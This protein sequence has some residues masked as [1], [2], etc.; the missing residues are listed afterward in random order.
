MFEGGS[1]HH[2]E[3]VGRILLQV[4]DNIKSL[5]ASLGRSNTVANLD[6]VLARAEK[7]LRVK[8]EV[9]LN[10]V[11]QNRVHTLPSIKPGSADGA[12]GGAGA[13][14]G[15]GGLGG[16]AG[17]G[18]APQAPARGSPRRRRRPRSQPKPATRVRDRLLE[19]QTRDHFDINNEDHRQVGWGSTETTVYTPH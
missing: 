17:G 9:V 1:S 10:S 12:T 19:A 6:E 14:A 13:G 18:R 7:D 3:D 5:R 15:A 4:Q 16:T 2:V 8:A 11:I